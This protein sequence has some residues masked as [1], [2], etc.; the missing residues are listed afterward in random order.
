M[1][2]SVVGWFVGIIIALC[3]MALGYLIFF[4]SAR[5]AYKGE[6]KPDILTECFEKGGN[7]LT[8]VPSVGKYVCL[9]NSTLEVIK[10]F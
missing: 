9:K 5:P 6:K 3:L 2:N 8:Y 10:V 7:Q 1:S 4:T